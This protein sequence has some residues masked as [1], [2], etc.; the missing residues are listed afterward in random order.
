[1]MGRKAFLISSGCNAPPAVIQIR[2]RAN[3][4]SNARFSITLNLEYHDQKE[5]GGELMGLFYE[6]FSRDGPKNTPASKY[7]VI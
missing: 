1:M 6:V 5:A 3:V 7:P 2:G 4:S